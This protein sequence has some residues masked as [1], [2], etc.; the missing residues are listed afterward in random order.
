MLGW[1]W[2]E[3]RCPTSGAVCYRQLLSPSACAERDGISLHDSQLSSLNHKHIDLWLMTSLR[4]YKDLN[5]H[6]SLGWLS[7]CFIP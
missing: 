1:L 7:Y 4:P 3:Q 5:L 2:S 6:H